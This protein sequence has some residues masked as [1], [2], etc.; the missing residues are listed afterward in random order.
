MSKEYW[1]PMRSEGEPSSPLDGGDEDLDLEYGPELEYGT[2]F[3]SGS[4][5]GSGSGD[6]DGDGGGPGPGGDGCE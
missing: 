3:G 2:N 4:G 5:S 6:D 1:E